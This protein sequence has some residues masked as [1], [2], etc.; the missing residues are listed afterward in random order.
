MSS[1]IRYVLENYR[2]I[3]YIQFSTEMLISTFKNLKI[4]ILNF[5]FNL[6]TKNKK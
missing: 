5:N 4:H 3:V 1:K 6:S 2:A